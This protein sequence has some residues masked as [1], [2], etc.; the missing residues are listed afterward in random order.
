M[1][2]V[3]FKLG[4]AYYGIN[5]EFID[6][7]SL[8]EPLA[9]VPL[10]ESFIKGIINVRGKIMPVLCLKE[11]LGLGVENEEDSRRVL[12]LTIK[13]L[14]AG[15]FV[16]SVIGVYSID[17]NSIL[18]TPDICSTDNVIGVCKLEDNLVSL[19]DVVKMFNMGDNV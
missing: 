19:F 14:S 15:L 9:R 12:F 18:P 2:I 17:E 11:F 4:D 16:D 5:T 13:D 3:V 6:V 7:I 10:V 1:Q 8:E